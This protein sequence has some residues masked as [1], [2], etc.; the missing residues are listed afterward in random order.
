MG[1]TVEYN[2]SFPSAGRPPL[3]L[4]G[5]LAR[6]STEDQA[7]DLQA[8][9]L[10][11]HP[12]PATSTMDDPLLRRLASELADGGLIALRFNFR[13]VGRSQGQQTDGRLEPLDIAGAMDFLLAQPHINPDK[14]CIVGHAFG[15]YMALIYAAHD[16]RVR[17]VVAISPPIFRVTPDLGMFDR[18]KLFLTGEYDEVSPRYKL[19]PWLERLPNRRLN[20]VS[21][22]RHL[23]RGYEN[24]ASTSITSYLVRWAGTP[25]M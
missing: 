19:E 2:I 14:L 9:A 12:Q 13:G 21:G 15:A 7:G 24:I 17:T 18:P 11:C 22:A 1:E 4:E 10:L 8:G 16:L 3:T 20:I 6:P 25:G 23:M 5:V